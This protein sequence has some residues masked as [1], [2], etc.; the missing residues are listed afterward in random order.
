MPA[1]SLWVYTSAEE[2]APFAE[3]SGKP[4][5]SRGKLWLSTTCQWKVLIFTQLMASRVRWMS[6]TGKL[7][8]SQLANILSPVPVYSLISGGVQHETTVGLRHNISLQ[9]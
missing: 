7:R 3:I 5:T 2:Y 4:G 8:H 1:T 9:I 6:E